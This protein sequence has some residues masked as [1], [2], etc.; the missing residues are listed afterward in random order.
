MAFLVAFAQLGNRADAEDVCQDGF[1]RVWQRIGDCRDPERVAS[2][3][4]SV[5]RNAAHNRREFLRLRHTESLDAAAGASVPDRPDVSVERSELRTRLTA[6][7]DQL[8]AAQREV[9]LLHD[10]EGWK[11]AEIAERLG[12]SEVTSR[13][14]LS[15][16]RRRLRGLL[17]AELPTLEFDHD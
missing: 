11:H 12:F 1:F 6:A 17:G 9:V 5:I 15:D 16:G 3:I 14:H 10:L 2:W 13:R 8:S 4:A 7:L